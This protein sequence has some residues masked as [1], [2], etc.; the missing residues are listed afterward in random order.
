MRWMS[1]VFRWTWP[2]STPGSMGRE[3]RSTGVTGCVV[4]SFMPTLYLSAQ[5]LVHGLASLEHADVLGDPSGP[6]LGPIRVLD[7]V[8]DR[9]AVGARERG[10]ERRRLRVPVELGL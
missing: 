6:R 4:V 9:V 3:P 8:E 1:A 7:P 5:S 10:E 2:M